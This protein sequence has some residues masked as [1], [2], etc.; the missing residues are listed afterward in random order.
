MS[1]HAA[2]L[3]LFAAAS[4][5][6]CIPYV[7]HETPHVSGVVVDAST[8]RVISGAKAYFDEH[9]QKAVLTDGSG[10]FDISAVSTIKVMPLAPYDF[11]PEDLY[12][13]I[14]APGYRALR[15]KA[16]TYQGPV[17]ETFTLRHE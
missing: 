11:F 4:L 7:I 10:R 17:G 6:G 15:V 5:S 8:R 2:T 9:D 16:N 13:I 12:L 1:S 3:L 14:D